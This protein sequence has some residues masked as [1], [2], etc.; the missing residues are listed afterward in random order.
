MSGP[1]TRSTLTQAGQTALLP[2]KDLDLAILHGT[3]RPV[4]CFAPGEGQPGLD[5][6]MR[7]VGK[8]SAVR[9]LDGM[10]HNGFPAV[11]AI[12]Q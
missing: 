5:V 12:D 6:R 9:L 1:T 7:K 10:L 8:T 2:G 11:T 4:S 3:V